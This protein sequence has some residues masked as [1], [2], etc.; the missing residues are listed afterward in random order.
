MGEIAYINQRQALEN[1]ITWR[2]QVGPAIV[3]VVEHLAQIAFTID[4]LAERTR[5]AVVP[6][7]TLT[8]FLDEIN[9]IKTEYF[10]TL[11]VANALQAAW[12][13]VIQ[14]TPDVPSSCAAGQRQMEVTDTPK[15]TK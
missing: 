1:L 9:A 13:S 8:E 15:G 6:E 12:G 7:S 3:Q 5:R 2:Q 10:A 4:C 14:P 11:S